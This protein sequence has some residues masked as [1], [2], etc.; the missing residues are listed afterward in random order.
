MISMKKAGCNLHD[1]NHSFNGC[2]AQAR[3]HHPAYSLDSHGTT[4]S[5]YPILN[6]LAHPVCLM[7][8]PFHTHEP[9][10]L[11]A[12]QTS[13]LSLLTGN[14]NGTRLRP[15]SCQSGSRAERPDLHERLV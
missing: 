3:L 6:K 14:G 10:A 15:V 12:S 2:S 13:S 11:T 4:Q 5:S 8:L 7:Q 1:L 9:R